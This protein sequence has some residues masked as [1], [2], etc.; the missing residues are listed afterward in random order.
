LTN[1][2]FSLP[3]GASPDANPTNDW[4]GLNMAAVYSMNFPN[5]PGARLY[6]HF[7]SPNGST[8][9]QELKWDQADDKW[10]TG[11]ALTGASPNSHIAATI[12]EQ[13]KVVRVFYSTENGTLQESWSNLT[14]YNAPYHLGK[15]H[16][17][18]W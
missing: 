6:Y 3:S 17:P 8:W 18:E 5:G 10:E 16:I 9:I 7:T 15:P 4:D 2:S 1:G 13:H 14:L 12:D 11:A